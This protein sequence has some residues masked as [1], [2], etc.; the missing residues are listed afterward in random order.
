M[1]EIIA[2][3]ELM[4]TMHDLDAAL[5]DLSGFDF[6]RSVFAVTGQ[7]DFL[8]EVRCKSMWDLGDALDKLTGRVWVTGSRSSKVKRIIKEPEELVYV[9]VDRNKEKNMLKSGLMAFM[10][11]GVRSNLLKPLLLKIVDIPQIKRIYET[12]GS[13]D[14]LIELWTKNMYEYSLVVEDIHNYEFLRATN[15]AFILRVKR[16][17]LA[18]KE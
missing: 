1:N 13:H 15:T 9:D 17:L 14:L 7:Y 2:F 18:E 11:I 3:V 10:G 6:V 16:H 12:T 4:G 5:E 8:V